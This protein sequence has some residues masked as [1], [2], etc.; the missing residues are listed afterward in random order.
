METTKVIFRK[1]KNGEIVAIF[2]DESWG[3]GLVTSYM[4]VGQHSEADYNHI[5]S[6]T[7]LATKS[8]YAPL[9]KELRRIGYT[10]LRVMKRRVFSHS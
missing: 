9:L 5:V 3:Y 6:V 1:F 4:H 2:P 10:N 7:K 8:E